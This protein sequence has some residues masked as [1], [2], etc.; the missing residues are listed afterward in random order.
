MY[1]FPLHIY[2]LGN[3]ILQSNL[4]IYSFILNVRVNNSIIILVIKSEPTRWVSAGL[5]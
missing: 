3:P 5:S 4:Y 1:R 2:V